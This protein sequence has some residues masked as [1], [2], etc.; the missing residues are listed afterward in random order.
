MRKQLKKDAK[1]DTMATSTVVQKISRRKK[2]LGNRTETNQHKMPDNSSDNELRGSKEHLDGILCPE[3]HFKENEQAR[4]CKND[5]VPT[6]TVVQEISKKKKVLVNHNGPNQHKIP[7]NSSD[8][9]LRGSEKQ[10]M[11]ALIK[12]Q[13]TILYPE[14]H[15]E[16][17][18]QIKDER[19]KDE[20]VKEERT[21]DEKAEDAR[22]KDERTKDEKD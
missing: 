7:D 4:N 9:G 17:D 12:V 13:D 2:I 5:K 15:L 18:E 3:V 16:E 11:P 19:A 20:Q 10:L 21:K 8:N 1:D 6:S 14:V 22:A